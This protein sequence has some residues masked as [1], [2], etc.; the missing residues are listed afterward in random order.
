M[1]SL[2]R[3]GCHVL[4]RCVCFFFYNFF[5]FIH[6]TLTI[7]K[8]LLL[9][10]YTIYCDSISHASNQKSVK[11][12]EESILDGY[13]HIC[14]GRFRI[15]L[16]HFH[17]A[18]GLRKCHRQRLDFKKMYHFILWII[19][20]KLLVLWI[21]VLI[22]VLV[23]VGIFFTNDV[24]IKCCVV[25]SRCFHSRYQFME[26]H[27]SFDL[28]LIFI[29]LICF[30]VGKFMNVV[31]SSNHIFLFVTSQC[32]NVWMLWV[33]DVFCFIHQ[34]PRSFLTD[35]YESLEIAKS[36]SH[37]IPVYM[38]SNLLLFWTFFF[39]TPKISTLV[40]PVNEIEINMQN[41][42]WDDGLSTWKK[43]RRKMLLLKCLYHIAYISFSAS[44]FECMCISCEFI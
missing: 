27:F 28:F 26:S 2:C 38:R 20:E 34:S 5:F 42:N 31:L 25:S 21:F 24:N 40:T 11:M 23:W 17:L 43:R 22:F 18:T 14:V 16:S 13:V 12:A 10:F 35:R 4:M 15:K 37:S 7:L 19:N 41:A 32:L 29:M 9:F 6:F 33:C 1:F 39:W 8:S 30:C 44:S 36:T 3:H